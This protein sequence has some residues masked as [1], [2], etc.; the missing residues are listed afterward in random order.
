VPRQVDHVRRR[1]EIADAT[2]KVLSETGTRGLSFRAV[3]SEMGGSTTLITHYFPT[4]R[5]LLDYV[6]AQMLAYSDEQISELDAK[7]ETSAGRLQALLRW[8][9]PLT[10]EGRMS[11]RT[12]FHLLTDQFL[13]EENL[14]MFQAWD[15]KIRA[16]IRAHVEGLVP[17][18]D[19]ER[20]VELIL[21][22]TNGIVLSVVEQPDLWPAERQIAVL[23][24]LTESLGI[25]P[26]DAHR[27]NDRLDGHRASL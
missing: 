18:Q 17:S 8:L 5:D 23:D 9:V 4:Q 20:A 10:E 16:Q 27:R 3:A 12:R 24:W 22:T 1:R 15:A 11:E 7:Q 2:L 21:V 19:V 13:G 6:I 26:D 25:A 14:S